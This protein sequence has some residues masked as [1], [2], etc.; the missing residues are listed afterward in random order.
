[1]ASMRLSTK[2]LFQLL[3]LLLVIGGFI[4]TLFPLYGGHYEEKSARTCAETSPIPFW[5]RGFARSCCDIFPTVFGRHSG[6]YFESG[7]VSDST[8]FFKREIRSGDIVYVVISDFPKFLEKFH[9]LKGTMRITLVTGG[10][11]IGA[12]WEIFHPDRI[13]YLSYKMS[14]LWP[15]GQLMTMREFL[16]DKR[17]VRWY[18]QN[19]DMVGN[20]SFTSSDIDVVADKSIVE[21]VFPLPIGLDFH[22]LAEKKRGIS[23]N[24]IA[25]SLCKQRIDIASALSTSLPFSDRK[26]SVYAKF[27]CLFSNIKSRHIRLMTRGTICKLLESYNQNVSRNHGNQLIFSPP[28]RGKEQKMSLQ[29]AKLS[30]WSNVAEVQFALAPPGCGI[31]THRAWEI[32]NLHTIPIVMSSPLDRLYSMFPAVIVKDWSEVFEEGS[33]DRFK[34]QVVAKFGKDPFSKNVDDMLKSDYWVNMIRN[35]SR[36]I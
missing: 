21:K 5:S 18:T 22:T 1:M 4:L 35:G 36:E 7:V 23:S 24:G 12:P 19:Y 30:Y 25:D 34:S 14:S 13:N 9:K 8:Y 3:L 29:D 15:K 10:E 33:L 27:D 20:N 31:D 16:G 32:L 6:G 17:L 11:D 2:V 28:T 26:L